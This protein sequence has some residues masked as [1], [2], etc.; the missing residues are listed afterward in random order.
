MILS[1]MNL[2]NRIPAKVIEVKKGKLNAHVN[3]AWGA[4]PLSVIITSGSVVEMGLEEG[5]EIEALFKASDVILAKNFQGTISARNIF[6]GA[7]LKI[8]EG[9]PLAMVYVDVNRVTVT[10]EI[11]LSSLKDL[12][13]KPGDQVEVIIKSTELVLA[14]I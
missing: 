9:F 4:V 10:A 3:L 12:K 8:T 13:I 6:S 14:R 1:G 7:V 2:K 5:D 11:T